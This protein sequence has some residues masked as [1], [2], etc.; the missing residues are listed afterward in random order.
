MP[1]TRFVVLDSSINRYGYRVKAENMTTEN[2]LK[3]PVMFYRHDRYQGVIGKWEDLKFE[4]GQWTALAVFDENDEM[5]AKIARQVTEGFLNATS[6]GIDVDYDSIEYEAN[7]LI[8]GQ[9]IPVATKFDL[10][11]IS[12]ADIPALANATRLACMKRNVTLSQSDNGMT[13]EILQSILSTH[14][15]P[16]EIPMK[17]VIRQLGLAD[18]ATE[19][20]ALQKVTELMSQNTGLN[21]KLTSANT[22]IK[23]L[24]DKVAEL[25]QS[26][27]KANAKVL[28]DAALTANKIT[29]AEEA[30]YLSLAELNYDVVKALFDGK[31]A[32]Q[33]INSQLNAGSQTNNMLE[34]RKAWTLT[35][36]QKK[37]SEGLGNLRANNPEAYQALIKSVKVK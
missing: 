27:A 6:V 4:N 35:D 23:T 36:W 34:D 21:G 28:V 5:G 31:T 19:A 22:T 37:D 14:V 7:P 17:T 3:N 33:S 13:A 16:T 9:T 18:N 32:Y 1:K 30:H 12:I 15:N 8:P 2:F 26:S 11:E 25:S 29:K 10:L 20:E 24:E